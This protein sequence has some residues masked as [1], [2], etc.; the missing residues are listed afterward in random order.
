MRAG[1]ATANSMSYSSDR[2]SA[3]TVV[4]VHSSVAD[5]D[6][7]VAGVGYLYCHGCSDY[8]AMM[9]RRGQ[10]AGYDPMHV[11]A[12]CI[13]FLH[14]TAAGKATLK[15]MPLKKLRKYIEAYNIALDLA[16]EKD[17]LIEAILRARR[18]NGCLPAE[19]ENYYRRYSVPDKPTA[20]R[21]SRL[22]GRTGQSSTSATPAPPP[23]SPPSNSR[24]RQF[25]RP[26]LAP[27]HPP[28]QQ[29]Y[30]PPPGP[31]PPPRQ[32][33]PQQSYPPPPPVPPRPQHQ[34]PPQQQQHHQHH[35]QQPHYHQSSNNQQYHPNH[36]PPRPQA[37]RPTPTGYPQYQRPTAARSSENLRRPSGNTSAPPNPARPARP[38]ATSATPQPAPPPPPP[39][40]DELLLLPDDTLKAL[41]ISSLKAVLFANHVSAGQVL[42]K[43]D[44]V[45]KVRVLVDAE[46]RE[47][48][49]QRAVEEAEEE[50]RIERQRVMM[51]EHRRKM[52][53]R[54][55][56]EAQAQ[57]NVEADTQQQPE[58]E[59]T[60]A[61]STSAPTPV[62]SPP[63][64]TPPK[65]PPKPRGTV[66][67]LERT[68]LCVICQD[69][70]ANIAIV[71][72]G[73]VAL[74]VIG[75]I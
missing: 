59:T 20:H 62:P 45:A 37:P 55:E 71:D 56:A 21:R 14:I 49:R 60:P 61:P 24:P 25:A 46:R 51:E 40:L 11:C 1:N 16:V 17:D 32:S 68:G 13:E 12:F 70:E 65:T 48:E 27:D 43:G 2:A 19:N 57:A 30:A 28:Q 26:D 74:L 75:L 67:D 23:P 15:G 73:Y 63:P 52:R 35:H 58:D 72:C 44:L 3:D 39:T 53:E 36:P 7:N 18:S 34:P 4:G 33:Y 41:S 54:E 42:E 29:R 31:P 22:F 10:E 69:E 38:R 66:A 50:E 6:C 8:Q 47:R 5:A 9:P 64:K